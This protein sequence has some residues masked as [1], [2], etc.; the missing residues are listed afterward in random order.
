MEDELSFI[1]LAALTANVLRYLKMDKQNENR[2]AHGDTSKN[3]NSDDRADI[4][5]RLREG[6]PHEERFGRL[7]DEKR[8][9]R[10][11]P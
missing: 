3:P 5:D 7:I 4:Q 6:T 10:T 9:G 11:K 8:R 1:S 2:P